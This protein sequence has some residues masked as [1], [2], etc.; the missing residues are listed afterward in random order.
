MLQIKYEDIP[1]LTSGWAALPS[2]EDMRNTSI[3]KIVANDINLEA[4][5]KMAIS[6]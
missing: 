2:L 4:L 6:N 3:A 5:N 1:S